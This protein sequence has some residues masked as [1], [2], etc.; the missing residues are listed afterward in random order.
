[1]NPVPR[2]RRRLTAPIPQFPELDQCVGRVVE[3]TVLD[4][5]AAESTGGTG[6]S[7]RAAAPFCQSTISEGADD[8]LPADPGAAV[9]RSAPAAGAAHLEV[10]PAAD[11]GDG[12]PEAGPLS[13][14]DEKPEH[15]IEE[16]LPEW[17]RLRR[18]R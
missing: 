4:E 14:A 18:G 8:L 15:Q 13:P 6:P 2:I 16:F 3:I 10:T 12:Q 9:P 17:Q 5:Q 7:A 11:D 1:V